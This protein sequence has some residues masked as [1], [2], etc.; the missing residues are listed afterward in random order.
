MTLVVPL[1][2]AWW[3]SEWSLGESTSCVYLQLGCPVR[4]PAR[5]RRAVTFLYNL[6]CI[7]FQRILRRG[8]QN[9]QRHPFHWKQMQDKARFIAH[10]P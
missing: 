2:L 3:Q 10:P 1:W 6:S 4:H 7:S 5:A 8:A 9:E